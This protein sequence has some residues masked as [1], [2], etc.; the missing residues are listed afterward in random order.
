MSDVP[1]VD[2]LFRG[3]VSLEHRAGWVKPWRVPYRDV[4]LFPPDGLGGKAEIPAGVRLEFDSQ[5][6]AVTVGIVP[7]TQPTALDCVVDGR[8]VESRTIP[9]GESTARLEGLDPRRKRI[10]VFLPHTV[11][12]RLTGLSV[13][14]GADA[15]SS[16]R[17][18]PRWITYGS[19]ITQC[20][21]AASP[22]QTWPA[23]V[24]RRHG[25][26]LTCLGFGGQ[27]HIE[28][29]V[30]RMIRDR[31]AELISLCLGIN[32]YGGASLG[33]RTFGAAVLGFVRIVREG[34]PGVPVAVISPIFSPPRETVPNR[35]GLSLI[36]IREEVGQAVATLRS[37]GD[38]DVHYVDG[39]ELFGEE[40]AEHLPDALHP[41]AEGYRILAAN[42]SRLV[43]GP[44]FGQP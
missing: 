10:A 24:A 20:A 18:R 6:T 43:A 36:A 38:P 22:A 28:P 30:A 21:A 31:P 14:V 26:D 9:P 25:L 13:D 44:V 16:V 15:E 33:P 8:L 4:A 32:V 40:H 29:M 34:H 3:A 35:V 2:A 11:P 19:S 37:C 23:L 27:C 5:T 12:V 41:D 1:L 7:S 42:F 39:R 17:D